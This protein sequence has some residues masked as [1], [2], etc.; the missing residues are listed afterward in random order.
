MI[1]TVLLPVNPIG[2]LGIITSKKCRRAKRRREYDKAQELAKK[3]KNTH[4]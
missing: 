1:A 4:C 3:V 2:F